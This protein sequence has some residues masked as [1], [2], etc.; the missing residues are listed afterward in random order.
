MK[1][2]LLDFGSDGKGVRS[3]T[4]GTKA[5]SLELDRSIL[6]GIVEDLSL[7][8]LRSESIKIRVPM[9]CCEI[10][11]V[12]GPI[13]HLRRRLRQLNEIFDSEGCRPWV[14][15]GDKIDQVH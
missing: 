4:G 6:E 9:E 15:N 13:C 1:N 10:I 5:S 12:Y 11:G 7:N 3:C 2:F 14:V 8:V